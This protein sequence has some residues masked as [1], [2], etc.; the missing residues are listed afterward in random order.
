VLLTTQYLDEADHLADQIVIIDLGRAIAQGTPA[1]L[2]KRA[3]RKVI[4]VHVRAPDDVTDV[5]NALHAIGD[6]DVQGEVGIRGLCHPW[7]PYDRS[8]L[9]GDGLRRRHHR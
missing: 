3:G 4:E 9:A 6:G 1:E 2:K 5:V 7:H 8:D